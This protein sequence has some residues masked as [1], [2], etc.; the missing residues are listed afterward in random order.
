MQQEA[1]DCKQKDAVEEAERARLEIAAKIDASIQEL[2]AKKQ[3][4]L[5]VVTNSPSSSRP[6]EGNTKIEVPL[7]TQQQQGR[8]QHSVRSSSSCSAG[9]LSLNPAK[10]E[11]VSLGTWEP[12]HN[13]PPCE[14]N[15]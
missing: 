13:A 15:S 5:G 8:I 7:P 1:A 9:A 2:V 3:A 11:D 10:T 4:L 6:R 12:V 14:I